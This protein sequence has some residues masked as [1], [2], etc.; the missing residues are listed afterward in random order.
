MYI[1]NLRKQ[2]HQNVHKKQAGI[3]KVLLFTWKALCCIP[4]TSASLMTCTIPS[5]QESSPVA[6]APTVKD[7]CN[8]IQW[9]KEQGKDFTVLLSL[10]HLLLGNSWPNKNI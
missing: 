3:I 10:P 8:A 9:F 2:W 6:V 7:C 4:P 5:L 1:I